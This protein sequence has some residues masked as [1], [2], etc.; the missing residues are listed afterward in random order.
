MKHPLSE[1]RKAS[2]TIAHALDQL[3]FV[4]LSLDDPIAFGPRQA[5]L[6]CRFIALNSQDEAA[7]IRGSG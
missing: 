3:Q 7:F 6:H 2:P 1:Q 5:R 4:D